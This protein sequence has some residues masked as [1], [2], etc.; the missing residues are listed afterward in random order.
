MDIA[1]AIDLCLDGPMHELRQVEELE[2]LAVPLGF[3]AA[4]RDE[5]P[6]QYYNAVRA[7]LG[8]RWQ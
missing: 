5:T 4:L 3:R 2:N 6:E 1:E 7:Y 8:K